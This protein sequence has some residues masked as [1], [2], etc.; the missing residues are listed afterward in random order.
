MLKCLPLEG[1]MHER[2]F[3]TTALH[4]RDLVPKAFVLDAFDNLR[5]VKMLRTF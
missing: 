2:N 4:I 3:S 5:T 1:L